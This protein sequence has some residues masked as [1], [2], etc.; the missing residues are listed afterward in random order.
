MNALQKVAWIELIVAIVA[1]VVVL[2]AIPLLG[3]RSTDLYGLLAIVAVIYPFLM[4]PKGGEIVKDERDNEIAKRAEYWG[5]STAWMFF[6][7]SMIVISMWH[8]TQD[9]PTK[10][11]FALIWIQFAVY[12]GVKGATA[13]VFYRR[14]GRAA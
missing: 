6:V 1:S 8:N 12:I 13:L 4:R 10:Y 2:G 14:V 7:I 9:V 5:G 11:L 3:E